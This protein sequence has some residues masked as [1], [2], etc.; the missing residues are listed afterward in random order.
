MPLLLN[1]WTNGLPDFPPP[2]KPR[3]VTSMRLV[4]SIVNA[5]ST[6]RSSFEVLKLVAVEWVTIALFRSV[7]DLNRCGPSI[8]MVAGP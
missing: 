7:S 6:V 4:A 2:R 8:V 1:D 5:V 3:A